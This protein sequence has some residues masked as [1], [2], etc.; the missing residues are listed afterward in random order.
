VAGSFNYLLELHT[1][2]GIS[3]PAERLLAFRE[4]LCCRVLV[5]Q[6]QFGVEWPE[7]L[8]LECRRKNKLSPT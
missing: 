5:I 8:F 1:S 7:Y 3:W 6:N 4:G 2:W